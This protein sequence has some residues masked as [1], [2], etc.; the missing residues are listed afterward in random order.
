MR[1]FDLPLA[2]DSGEAAE[3]PQIQRPPQGEGLGVESSFPELA[4]EPAVTGGGADET[5]R[6]TPAAELFS[7][8]E[9]HRLRTTG[10]IALEEEGNSLHLSV[11]ELDA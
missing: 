8:L 4:S 9:H 6:V 2:K 10:T 7:E 5:N 1:D 11:R 3:A